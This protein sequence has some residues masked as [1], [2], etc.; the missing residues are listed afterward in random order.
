MKRS[1][2][3]IT[4]IFVRS[5]W[6]AII[7]LVC[8][9]GGFRLLFADGAPFMEHVHEMGQLR[10]PLDTPA[11]KEAGS[12]E[13]LNALPVPGM[14]EEKLRS[15]EIQ[16]F[17][18]QLHNQLDYSL[19][20]DIGI[21]KVIY[22]VFL[23]RESNGGLYFRN[24]HFKTITPSLERLIDEF[25]FR[26]LELCAWMITRKFKWLESDL[27]YD[28]QYLEGKRSRVQK[29]DVFNPEAVLKIVA[30]Y[31]ELASRRINSILIQDDFILRYNEGF[32]NW[33]KAR[34]SNAAGVPAKE[35]LMMTRDTPYYDTWNKIKRKQLNQLLGMIVDNCKKVNSGIKIGLNIYYE[36]PVYPE[37]GE[38]W[39]GH[40][41]KELVETGVDYIYLMSYHRQIKNELKLSE[42]R[43]RQLFEE[44]VENAREI[45]RDKLIVKIQLRDW[46]TSERIPADEICAYLKLIHPRVKRICFTP[47]KKGDWD[48]LKNIIR[49]ADD[50]RVAGR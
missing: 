13:S 20:K 50:S 29:L 6:T 9:Y 39:Y 26:R 8:H 44:I 36:T 28:F 5:L 4:G 38:A 14:G 45:C 27:L 2:V 46:Q 37:K 33:G 30:V 25:D 31:K 15:Y 32:S 17:T 23:D 12:G 49:A 10:Q 1:T 35:K 34:F 3:P 19:L 48:Y 47:V 40:N 21:D 24:T 22:R 11:L 16:F 42:I 41:L 7:F 18:T 43:N